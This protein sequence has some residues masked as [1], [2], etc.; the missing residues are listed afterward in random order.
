MAELFVSYKSE[1]RRRVAPL[2]AALREAGFDL[3]W[4]QDIAPGTSWRETI[5]AELDAGRLCLVIWTEGSVG[6]GGRYVREEAE[7]AMARG[8]YL[9]VMLDAASPPFG[10]G[11]TQSANL[12]GWNRRAKGPH[13]D[14]L[15]GLIRAR[16]GGGGPAPPPPPAGHRIDRRLVA[17]GAAALLIAAAAALYL[18]V[19]RPGPGRPSTADFAANVLAG[20]PCTW[21]EVVEV[22]AG[23][24]GEL[25]TLSGAAAAPAALRVALGRAASA[26]GIRL[27]DIDV[28][29]VATAHNDLC[30]ELEF[31]RGFK[32]EG[33][34]RLRVP[35]PQMI[36]P[37]VARFRLQVDVRGLPPHRALFGLDPAD[38]LYM[39]APDRDA[40]RREWS[41]RTE[42]GRE[43]LEG[44]LDHEGWSALVLVTGRR[45]IDT[46]F[47]ERLSRQ[48][49][50]AFVEAFS[51]RARAEGWAFHLG[52]IHC[53]LS[54][55]V[56]EPC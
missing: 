28:S 8:A 2:V 41:L 22:A 9:G 40:I 6:A 47:I 55:P 23:Q 50:P 42:A 5:A 43:W 12:S 49:D 20:Q 48:N 4:D 27:A 53:D 19:L 15:V 56:D 45:P 11:E 1:D 44:T 35:P 36:A 17:A 46:G 29:D 54:R 39:L 13:V 34:A 30:D 51:R 14:Y 32:V 3:W 7:R 52:A 25:L 31:L 38:G 16:L 24:D 37:R 10:F 33:R 18:L 21:V 26:A